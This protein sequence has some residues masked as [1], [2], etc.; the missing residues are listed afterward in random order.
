MLLLLERIN[1]F[2]E[3]VAKRKFYELDELNK[4][5][6]TK[7]TSYYNF[8]KFVLIP[9]KKDLDVHSNISFIYTK[10]KDKIKTRG[11][12]RIVGITIDLTS[13]QP[14]LF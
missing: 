6:G 12:A 10:N 8:E 7:Y 2:S 9:A 5:F 1:N 13:N 3:N 14:S 4:L 11:R